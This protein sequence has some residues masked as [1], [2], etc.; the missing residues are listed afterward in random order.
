[1]TQT[2]PTTDQVSPDVSNFRSIEMYLINDQLARAHHDEM[3]MRAERER[4]TR[5]AILARRMERRAERAARRARRL[6]AAAITY[7]ART[8]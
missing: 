7:R 3:L 5:R 1:M 6:T 8:Y 4:V 2:D